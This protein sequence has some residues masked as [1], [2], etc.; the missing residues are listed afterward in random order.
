MKNKFNYTGAIAA[1]VMA[2]AVFLPWVSSSNGA[3]SI[4]GFDFVDLKFSPLISL[5]GAF[6]AFKRIRWVMLLIGI[7]NLLQG[8]LHLCY[9]ILVDKMSSSYSHGMVGVRP[10]IGLIIFLIAALIFLF[11][12]KNLKKIHTSISVN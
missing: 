4:I 2:A 12:A 8:L 6:V 1:L 11:A 3:D 10:S 7:I 5:A 9:Y